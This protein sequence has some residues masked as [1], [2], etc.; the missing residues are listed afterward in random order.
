MRTLSFVCLLPLLLVACT[1]DTRPSRAN[2]QHAVDVK[3]NGEANRFDEKDP[4]WMSFQLADYSCDV[5]G[6]DEADCVV[7]FHWGRGID[8]G[9]I[10]MRKFTSGWSGDQ[11]D[12]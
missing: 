12:F 3:L 7:K 8:E 10:I 11:Y 9:H 2:V 6:T 5:K 1:D 4:R